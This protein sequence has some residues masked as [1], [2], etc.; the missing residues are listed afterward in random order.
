MYLYEI[1]QSVLTQEE[2]KILNNLYD[3]YRG[4]PVVILEPKPKKQP[5]PKAKPKP[6]AHIKY[7]ICLICYEI[8]EVNEFEGDSTICKECRSL[9]KME[10][11]RTV[12]REQIAKVME[13]ISEQTLKL[14]LKNWRFKPYEKKVKYNKSYRF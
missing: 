11:E 14:Y 3:K 9:K 12:K 6:K 10:Q 8:K 1:N 5:K 13:E 2:E 4:L 7:R